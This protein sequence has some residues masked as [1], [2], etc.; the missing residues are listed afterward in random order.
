MAYIAETT[1]NLGLSH[2]G[3]D[4]R[5]KKPRD[6]DGTL[7]GPSIAR[8]A[9]VRAIDTPGPPPPPPPSAPPAIP[10]AP[11]TFAELINAV[12]PSPPPKFKYKRG[13]PYERAVDPD[14]KP[15]CNICQSPDHLWRQC[16]KPLPSHVHSMATEFVR[17][18][19][20][21]EIPDDM[22]FGYFVREVVSDF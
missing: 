6:F 15:L 21:Q 11:S 9:V 19:D 17:Q 4:L 2:L 10:R 16:P 8:A 20:L 3:V 5:N 18:L 7:G 22:L 1:I 13:S 12:S 14:G